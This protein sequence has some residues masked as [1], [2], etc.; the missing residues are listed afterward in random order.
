[1]MSGQKKMTGRIR[2]RWLA[3]L[4][5]ALLAA[6]G[7][8]RADDDGWL[9]RPDGPP[10]QKDGGRLKPDRRQG[11]EPRAADPL[12]AS[13]SGSAGT[14]QGGATATEDVA[15]SVIP[16]SYKTP[17]DVLTQLEEAAKAGDPERAVP[18]FAEPFGAALKR[19]FAAGH[20][21][22]DASR[23][24]HKAVTA[25]LGTDAAKALS[26]EKRMANPARV[27]TDTEIAII[28][29]NERGDIAT[30]VIQPR[31]PFGEGR[32]ETVEL[33]KQDGRWRLMPPSRD[34]KPFGE[35][36]L[37]Q[38]ESLSRGLE[39]AAA[40]VVKLASDVEWGMID[41]VADCRV[42]L[43]EADMEVMKSMLDAGTATE[44]LL[45]ETDPGFMK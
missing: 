23:R 15:G 17:R 31:S 35:Q 37:L 36:E 29:I 16:V 38:M 24:L 18:L 2:T 25:R 8:V 19:T 21:M 5:A 20:L 14:V 42:R 7:P 44:D 10:V 26:L 4:A 41:S 9:E 3:A 28:S 39:N 6:G 30:A 12:D 1:M 34:G 32:A 45:L 27:P 43:D 13:I 40:A 22:V 33:V 11:R